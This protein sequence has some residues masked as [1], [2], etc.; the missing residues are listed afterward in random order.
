MI[1]HLFPFSKV[2]LIFMKNIQTVKSLLNL[3]IIKIFHPNI[4]QMNFFLE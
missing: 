4:R 1:F 2:I 3:I